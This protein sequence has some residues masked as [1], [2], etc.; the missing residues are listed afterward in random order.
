MSHHRHARWFNLNRGAQIG[1]VFE[2][3]QVPHLY[4]V[5]LAG[6]HEKIWFFWGETHTRNIFIMSRKD[7]LASE[8][9]SPEPDSVVFR[10]TEEHIP[11]LILIYA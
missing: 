8:V 1:Q 5:V 2:G 11:I 4:G 9:F 7:S 6:W 3:G 10:S